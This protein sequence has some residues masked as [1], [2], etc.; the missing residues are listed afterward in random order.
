MNAAAIVPP[1]NLPVPTLGQLIVRINENA[2]LVARGEHAKIQLGRDLL[3]AKALVAHGE[4]EDWCAANLPKLSMR[5]IRHW[6]KIANAPD[7]VQEHEKCNRDVK[8]K[9]KQHRSKRRNVT[10][11]S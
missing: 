10:P 3:A 11:F 2:G 7:P 6:M 4:W 9:M 8:E 1:A 5:Q